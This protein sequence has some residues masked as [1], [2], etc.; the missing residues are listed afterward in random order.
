MTSAAT[1][2]RIGFTLKALLELKSLTSLCSSALL[3]SAPVPSLS[4][5][6]N[7]EN[8]S[9]SSSSKLSNGLGASSSLAKPDDN[10]SLSSSSSS[11]TDE[12]VEP[13]KSSSSSSSSNALN[14]SF[15]WSSSLSSWSAMR[16]K[17]FPPGYV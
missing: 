6:S 7:A 3:I 2:A 12:P 9:S 11:F 4:L 17:T 14:K 13:N 1:P 5:L 16:L 10:N 15:N 8:E